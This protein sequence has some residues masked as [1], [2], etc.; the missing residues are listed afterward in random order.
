[1]KFNGWQRLG[2]VLSALWWFTCLSL[3]LIEYLQASPFTS[4]LFV[5]YK[6]TSIFSIIPLEIAGL[7]SSET[8]P[9]VNTLMVVTALLMPILTWLLVTVGMIMV[10]WIAVGFEPLQAEPPVLTNAINS[11]K[12]H[13]ELVS[14]AE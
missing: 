2:I 14:Q 11:K 9:D 6:S 3:Y 4:T 5:A 10:R 8:I 12:F 13:Q 7:S 1:M